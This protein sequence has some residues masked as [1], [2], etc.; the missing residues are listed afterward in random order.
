MILSMSVPSFK[1]HRVCSWSLASS[2]TKRALKAG[3]G[4]DGRGWGGMGWT[5]VGRDGVDRAGMGRG[6]E[7]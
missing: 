1:E 6:E 3:Q 5:G 7:G 2:H 4:R